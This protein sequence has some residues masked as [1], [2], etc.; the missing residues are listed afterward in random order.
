MGLFFLFLLKVCGSYNEN[1]EGGRSGDSQNAL[2]PGVKQL[3]GHSLTLHKCHQIKLHLKNVLQ[4][5][6]FSSFVDV[7]RKIRLY[8]SNR[9]L[10]FIT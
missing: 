3:L 6:K 7:K 9:L 10:E 4:L 1:G 5:S 8:P 2:V